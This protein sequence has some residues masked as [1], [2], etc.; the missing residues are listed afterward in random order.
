MEKSEKN[1][2]LVITLVFSIVIL[3]VLVAIGTYS[4]YTATIKTNHEENKKTQ[5]TTAKLDFEIIDG[6]LKGSNLIPGDTITKTFQI[7]NNGTV[8]G[9]YAIIWKSAVNNFVNQKDLIVTLTEDGTEIVKSSDL[10]TFP[11]TTTTPVTIKDNLKIAPGKTKN[12]ILTITYQNTEQD[13]SGD[14]GKS[15]SAVIDMLV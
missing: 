4:F 5:A 1:T 9:T 15:I 12:Y 10:Q 13:Q 8:E 6:T 14:M 2:R 7:K 11:R 3:V